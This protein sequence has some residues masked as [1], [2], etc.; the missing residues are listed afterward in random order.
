MTELVQSAFDYEMLPAHQVVLI[1]QVAQEIKAAARRSADCIREIGEMLIGIKKMIPHGH[2]GAWLAT[3]FQWSESTALRFMRVA[4]MFK[5][6]TVT[7]I[8]LGY[9]EEGEPIKSATVADLGFGARVLYMLSAPSTPE[10]V[11]EAA[12]EMAKAGEPVTAKTVAK[13]KA[14]HKEKSQPEPEPIDLGEPQPESEYPEEEDYDAGGVEDP[15]PEDEGDLTPD[16]DTVPEQEDY[17]EA[18][19]EM[20]PPE[21]P[22]MDEEDEGDPDPRNLAEEINASRV[23]C[24]RIAEYAEIENAWS[25]YTPAQARYLL[26][27]AYAERDWMNEMINDLERI[28][29]ES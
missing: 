26:A 7:D 19:Y 4:E 3:E 8:Y 22:E 14:E 24:E 21:E 17:D 1:Q 10:P 15:E 2:W 13:L 25:D 16:L 5:S 29:N 28:K 27:L 11:R 9:D 23:R 6:V 20:V 12:I 18:E